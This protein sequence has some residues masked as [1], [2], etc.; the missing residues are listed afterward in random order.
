MLVFKKVV[1][2]FWGDIFVICVC[3]VYLYICVGI[4]FIVYVQ[5]INE[6]MVSFVVYYFKFYFFELGVFVK[7]RVNKL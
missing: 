4:Y 2:Y 6:D 7:Y 5:R 3:V 1:V